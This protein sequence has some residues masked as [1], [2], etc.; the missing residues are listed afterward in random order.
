ME[1]KVFIYTFKTQKYKK[2][3]EYPDGMKFSRVPE[4]KENFEI[5]TIRC[6]CFQK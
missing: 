3:F 2:S 1:K 6:L 4:G 5:F